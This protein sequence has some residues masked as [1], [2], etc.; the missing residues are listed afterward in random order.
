M[1]AALTLLTAMH[2]IKTGFGISE[3][4][5]TSTASQPTHGPGQGSRLASAL[6]LIVSC[7]RFATM[8]TLCQGA[9]FC[10]PCDTLVH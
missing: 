6:W 9:S 5:H 3:G 4:T 10:D 7:M 8:D 1:M 2:S